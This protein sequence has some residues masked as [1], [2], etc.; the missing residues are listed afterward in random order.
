MKTIAYTARTR[1]WQKYVFLHA[2]KGY[3]YR[4]AL[5]IPKQLLKTTWQK[6][7][8]LFLPFQSVDLYHVYNCIVV[9][10]KPWIVEVEDA[11]PRY[12]KVPESSRIFQYGVSRLRS[13]DCRK[14]IFVSEYAREKALEK[15]EKWDI[16]PEKSTVIYRA[17]ECFEP[18][19]KQ[20]GIIRILFVGNGFYRKGGGMKYLK[21]SR[22]LNQQ[23]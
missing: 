6:N 15:L 21:P 19:E 8:R 20:D 22:L 17:V 9:N 14:I 16:S 12:G 18:L 5:E 10:K 23:R 7:T 1:Y 13:N 2:P 3:R 4:R 11:I